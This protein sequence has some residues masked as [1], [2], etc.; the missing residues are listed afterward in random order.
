MDNDE[1][2][3]AALVARIQWKGGE[4]YHVGLRSLAPCQFIPPK[5][6]RTVSQ[7]S[8]EERGISIAKVTDLRYF[9][10]GGNPPSSV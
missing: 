6:D 3:F 9:Q 1:A 5:P 2:R 8:L 4:W 7:V 10:S